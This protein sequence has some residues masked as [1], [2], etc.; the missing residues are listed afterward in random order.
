MN[1][2]TR[3]QFIVFA[4]IGA[5]I[6]FFIIRIIVGYVD[7][8][9]TCF[10]SKQNGDEQGIDCGGSCTL[11]C[12]FQARDVVILWQVATKVT[13][14]VYNIVA[15]L[16]NTNVGSGVTS[17]P[18]KFRIYDDQNL[19]IAERLGKTYISADDRFALVETTI[20]TGNRIPQRVFFEFLEQPL[21]QE[22]E[23]IYQQKIIR[24]R[25]QKI[26]QTTTRPRVVAVLEN[27]S[28]EFLHDIEVSVIVYNTQGN[29]IQIG[30]TLVNDMDPL[31]QKEI[32]FTWPEPIT[33]DIGR[34]EVI[35]RLN[36]FTQHN[37]I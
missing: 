25:S 23:P 19:I 36:G 28:Q 5:I 31:A 26:E 32:F 17:L 24:V 1:W 18:Y 4:T 16:E 34:I 8:E 21:W 29:V 37:R 30:K 3:R 2:R 11:V 6:L 14:G 15:Y 12:P 7:K 22:L 20:T 33:E 9:P 10:D 13:D 35:P 27:L